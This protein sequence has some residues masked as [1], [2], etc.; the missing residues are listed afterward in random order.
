M[1]DSPLKWADR[2][3]DFPNPRPASRPPPT[4]M[5]AAPRKAADAD[6]ES[7]K[8]V[9]ESSIARFREP[10]LIE[11]GEAPIPIEP[12]RW[13]LDPGPRGCLLHVWSDAGNLVRRVTAVVAETN[14]RVELR[15]SR[16]GQAD[17]P[18]SLIDRAA[19]GQAALRGAGRTVFREF[20]RRMIAR[21]YKGWDIEKLSSAADLERS[22]SPAV[23]R[24]VLKRGAARWAIVGVSDGQSA[25]AADRI[26]TTG[27]IWLD[28]VRRSRQGTAAGLKL[29]LPAGRAAATAQRVN[30]LTRDL[31]FEVHEFDRHGNLAPIDPADRGNL[32]LRLEPCMTPATPPGAVNDRLRE[33]LADERI[34]CIRGA[35]GVLSLQ[36]RGI[37]FA[38]VAGK[39][40]TYGLDRRSPVTERNFDRVAALAGEILRLRSAP[41]PDGRNPLY[42]QY[43]ERWL[44][45][46]VRRS[47]PAIDPLLAAE[48]I[49]ARVLTESGRER[50]VIDLLARGID[51]RLAVLELKASEDI[52]LPLQGLDYWMRVKWSLESGGF[53]EK[54]YFAGE[55]LSDRPPR[56]LL[57]APALAFH[58][59]TETILQFFAPE[60]PVERVGVSEDWRRKLEVAFRRAGA[61]RA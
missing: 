15:A 27:L 21:R 35:N 56:L 4:P 16:F 45:S 5:R 51:G 60:I 20:F 33:I 31:R 57:V 2:G 34:D 11:Q 12:N 59:T 43:P 32:Q 28:I 6:P 13:S 49:Y 7:V 8:R 9:I 17:A 47:I 53:R 10:L 30:F 24:A 52:H 1:G 42:T 37:E 44:E 36:A 50:G 48:P 25:A 55:P 41:P 54:G 3:A 58:P 23:A 46:Q 29:F 26:L 14:G 38:R 19:K 61:A 39:R 40:M 22:L 18:L